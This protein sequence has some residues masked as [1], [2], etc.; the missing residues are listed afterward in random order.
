MRG[1]IQDTVDDWLATTD[2]DQREIATIVIKQLSDD[3]FDNGNYT[4]V[5][6]I[7]TAINGVF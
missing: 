3:L 6:A 2:L 5:S 7:I 4:E 1:E